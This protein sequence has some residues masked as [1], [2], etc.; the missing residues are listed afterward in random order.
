LLVHE[1]PGSRPEAREETAKELEAGLRQ[2]PGCDKLQVLLCRHLSREDLEPVVDHEYPMLRVHLTWKDRPGAFL[3]VLD[4]IS[5]ALLEALPAIQRKDW[6]VSYAHLQV[7]TGQIALGRVTIRMHI[8]KR[9]IAGWNTDKME[10][11]ARKIEFLAAKVA[12]EQAVEAAKQTAS[13]TLA[14]ELL[15]PEEPVIRIAR[16]MKSG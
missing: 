1:P 4:S 16:I 12:A 15:T 11:M 5:K 10:E 6:S 13:D 9:D 3:N 2:E 7:L 14:D 8:P